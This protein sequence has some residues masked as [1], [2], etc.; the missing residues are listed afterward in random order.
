MVWMVFNL[1]LVGAD[2]S[3]IWSL[4][5]SKYLSSVTLSLLCLLLT[6]VHWLL[7]YWICDV[8]LWR[9][10]SWQVHFSTNNSSAV[11]VNKFSLVIVSQGFEKV[12]LCN[13]PFEFS[14]FVSMLFIKLCGK[15]FQI[16]LLLVNRSTRPE[17]FCK[18]G[19]LRDFAKFETL[20]QMFSCEFSEISKNTFSYRIPL[21]AAS[22]DNPSSQKIWI[23]PTMS[24]IN[25]SECVLV[26]LKKLILEI[27][28][29]NTWTYFYIRFFKCFVSS[30]LIY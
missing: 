24:C 6:F 4:S 19:V 22:V 10:Y 12:L 30:K 21:V 20:A 26:F 3:E 8:S 2:L 28:N 27:S 17:V 18:K 29:C 25:Y 7:A 5:V 16:S 11:C 9:R 13:P 14:W 23:C 1:L 15:L